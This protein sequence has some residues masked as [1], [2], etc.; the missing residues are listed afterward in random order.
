MNKIED[1]IKGVIYGQAIGDALG[2]GTEFLEL[3]EVHSYYPYPDGL[4]RYDQIVPDSHRRRWKQGAW[5][6]DTDMML[7]I[8]DAILEDKAIVPKTIARNFKRWFKGYPLGIG[9]NTY[10]VLSM[11]DYENNPKK[12]A[13]IVWDLSGQKSAANGA[14]MRTSIIGLWKNDVAKH[15]EAVCRLT[16]ADPRCVA[17]CVIVCELIHNLVWKDKLLS[18]DSLIELGRK[19]DSRVEEYIRLAIE[20]NS[21][22][23]LKLDEEPYIGYTL[24]TLSAGLWSLYHAQSFE[25][26]LLAVVNAGGDADTN[27]AVACSLLG[28]KYGYNSISIYYTNNLINQDRQNG[29]LMSCTFCCT[30]RNCHYPILLLL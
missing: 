4:T 10:N 18:S 21:I 13:Q 11:G 14:V 29:F 19:Y 26:G 24:K 7:A 17:S 15:A 16:H 23:S 25:E 6:D 30:S 28:A 3:D 12:A 5:T 2:L 22:L 1:K 27:G 8:A 20:S 9:R